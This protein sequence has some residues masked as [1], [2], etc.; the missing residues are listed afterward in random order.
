V[1]PEY[2]TA[3]A[4]IVAPCFRVK[5]DVLIVAGFIALI[6][7]AVIV[8]LSG[9]PVAAFAGFVEMIVGGGRVT[10]NVTALLVSP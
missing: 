7:V 10:V 5:V 1:L 4:I 3:P 8:W 2:V 9:T 6:N